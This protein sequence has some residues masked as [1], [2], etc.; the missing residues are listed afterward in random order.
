MALSRGPVGCATIWG[1][2]RR[3]EFVFGYGSLAGSPGPAASREICRQGFVADLTGFVRTWGVAMDNRRD[4]PGYKYYTDPAGRRPHVFV[5]FL[6]LVPS[7]A[8]SAAVNGLC[9]PVAEPALVVLDRRE[10]NYERVDVSD[11]I[12]AGG[13]R[14]WVYRGSV[15]GR[16]RCDEGRGAGT[17]VIDANYLRAVQAGF[18]ALGEAE[19]RQCG[20]SLDPG[21]TPVTE[22]VRHQL[23]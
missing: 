22:L 16:A 10:R 21:G 9:L 12:D 2:K 18:S 3:P 15:D 7:E 4:L 8:N 19:F 6:D 20:L 14:V 5:T 13:A 17:A 1:M 11:H 23:P